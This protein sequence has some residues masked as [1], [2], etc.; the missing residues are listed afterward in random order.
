MFDIDTLIGYR[1][2]MTK[3]QEF[4]NRVNDRIKELGLNSYK[5]YAQCINEGGYEK[6]Y[7]SFINVTTGRVRLDADTMICFGE[8]F[9]IR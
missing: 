3:S 2:I 7:Q 1:C 8:V 5:A 6:T 4:I 9:K